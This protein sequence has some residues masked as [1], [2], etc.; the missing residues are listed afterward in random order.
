MRTEQLYA[1]HQ[2]FVPLKDGDKRSDDYPFL[3]RPFFALL[4]H[5]SE[6]NQNNSSINI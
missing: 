2:D 1:C 3:I 4:R 6:K 5:C